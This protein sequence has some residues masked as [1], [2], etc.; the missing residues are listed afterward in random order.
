[1]S[2][3]LFLLDETSNVM[4]NHRSF[5]HS[6]LSK[7]WN[8][9]AINRDHVTEG[10]N[11]SIL[12]NL[13]MCGDLD[14]SFFIQCE[15][16]F[17]HFCVWNNTGAQNRYVRMECSLRCHDLAP[18]NLTRHRITDN[19]DSGF[20]KRS[21]YVGLY[22]GHACTAKNIRAMNNA[23]RASGIFFCKARNMRSRSKTSSS[24]VGPPPT[25]LTE[26]CRL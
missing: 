19:L 8:R 4:C 24:P 15:S 5:A 26:T 23:S 1:M 21:S 2:V 22:C 7:F 25:T 9:R 14:V 10:K 3:R 12:T 18:C 6:G 11:A 17:E 13:E 16:F 20:L